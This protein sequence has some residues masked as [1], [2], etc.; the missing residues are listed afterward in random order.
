MRQLLVF[1]AMVTLSACRAAK[2]SEQKPEKKDIGAET[3]DVASD[4]RRLAAA[5]AATGEVVRAAGDCE[6]VHAAL[7]EA[8]RQIEEIAPHVRTVSG[9]TTLDALRKRVND[10]AQACP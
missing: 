4:T 9:K 6:A 7:P 2:V 3:A 1:T 10:I 8:N 5:N